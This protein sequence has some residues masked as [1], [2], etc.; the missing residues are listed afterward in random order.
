MLHCQE[1]KTLNREITKR[2]EKNEEE[3][4]KTENPKPNFSSNVCRYCSY[5]NAA[6]R[7]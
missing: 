1:L 2:Q 7:T 6:A 3:K 5:Q 4:P